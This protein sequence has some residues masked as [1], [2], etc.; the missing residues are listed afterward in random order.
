MSQPRIVVLDG[1]T[2]A[3]GGTD[4]VH[5]DGFATLGP[6]TVHERTPADLVIQ[7]AAGA[8]AVL[9]NKTPI[10]A[11]HL[12][13]LPDLRY[14][15]VLATG[16][17][18]VDLDAAAAH[19]ITVTNIPGYSSDSVAQTVFALLLELCTHTSAHSAAVH[20]GKWASC[21]DF[22][23]TVNPITELS[24]KVMG[25]VGLG[26][27]GKRVAQIAHAF[28]MY[29]A[30]AHQSS[31]HRI[32]L[33]EVDVQWMTVDDLFAKSDVVS[34]HC[35]LTPDTR[36]LANNRTIGRM[37]PSAFLI[38]TGRGPLIDEV[39]LAAALHGK[40]IAGAGLDV[41]STEPPD[42]SNPLLK[43]PRCVIT[44]HIAWA[45]VEARTRLMALALRNLQQFLDGHPVNVVNA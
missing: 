21:P 29:V 13:H 4:T 3:P 26:S 24:G 20:Q 36:H 7:R 15:G 42:P 43:A 38:N 9:T 23:F 25:I 33:P 45:S 11:E 18:V 8:A 40:A 6:L 27:I 17:N 30:A 2:L 10:T 5:F 44:P 28:G 14:I 41:L 22:S 32:M 12:N 34:L 1:H 37:Q 39:A 19:G 35:P 31:M 16:V